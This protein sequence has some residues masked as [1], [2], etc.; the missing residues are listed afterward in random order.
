VPCRFD[1]G[2]ASHTHK[3]VLTPAQLRAARVF[4][5]WTRST[6]ARHSGV[7]VEAIRAFEVRGSDPRLTTIGKLRSALERAG[8]ELLDDD[9]EKGPGLRLR[10]SGKRRQ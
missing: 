10:R 4:L 6:L 1:I 2:V 8:V 9:G 3:G 5:G 7:S